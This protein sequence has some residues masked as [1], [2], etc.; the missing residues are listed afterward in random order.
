VCRKQ[1]EEKNKREDTAAAKID[2][3]IKEENSDGGPST[4][5]EKRSQGNKSQNEKMGVRVEF[6]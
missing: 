1:G 2:R 3:Y 4:I 6:S 5:Y